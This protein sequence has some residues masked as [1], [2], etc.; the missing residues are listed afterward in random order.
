MIFSAGSVK[1]AIFL[2]VA[3]VISLSVHEFAHAFA[4]H[5]C[6]DDTAYNFGRMSL[7]P[8]R[9]L[10]PF[11][12]LSMLFMGFGWAK[13]VPVNMRGLRKPRR[14]IALV[15]IAG[16]A[17]NF[18][19]A[20]FGIGVL[21]LLLAINPFLFYT[22]EDTFTQKLTHNFL[23]FFWYFC[24]LNVGL[25]IF[26]LIPIP[27]LDGSKILASL[28]PPKWGV[29]FIRLERYAP[30]FIMVIFALSYFD[31]FDPLFYPL[32]WLRAQILH[33]FTLPFGF[34]VTLF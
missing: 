34:G 13:P 16:P 1:D 15:S 30:I 31:I 28:L 6:G 24:I 21:R 8:L 5:K 7:N 26:N 17:S 2:I 32:V 14:D 11:G 3:A 19:M 29:R 12:F 27:P 18:I 23:D 33:L 25:G 10:D 22:I 9:H 4:A 20:F